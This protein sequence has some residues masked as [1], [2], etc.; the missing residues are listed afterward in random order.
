MLGT[1]FDLLAV[2][3]NGWPSFL[4]FGMMSLLFNLAFLMYLIHKLILV[5]VPFF[6][7]VFPFEYRL[8]VDSDYNI[9]FFSIS[10][11]MAFAN[12]LDCS[13]RGLPCILALHCVKILTAYK[14]KKTIYLSL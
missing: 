11:S 8:S 2:K 6:F 14:E 10:L 5:Q 13:E 3:T 12:I 7:L 1:D 4:V 9:T